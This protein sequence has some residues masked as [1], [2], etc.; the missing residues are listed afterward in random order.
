VQKNSFSAPSF[1]RY[2]VLSSASALL[3]CAGFILSP[4]GMAALLVSPTPLALL[5]ARENKTW[6]TLGLLSA[7]MA[8]WFILG[9]WFTLYFLFGY[10]LLCFGL[11]MPMGK[12]EKGSECLLFCVVVSIISKVLFVVVSVAL[13]GSNPFDVDINVLNNTYAGMLAT[14]DREADEALSQAVALIPYMFPFFIIVYSMCDSFINYRLC[15]ILQSK[16]EVKFPPLPPF[17]EW[18]FPSSILYVLVF[19]FAL[20]FV[21]ESG[22]QLWVMLELNLR[23]IVYVFFFLQGLALVWWW[24]SKYAKNAAG[25]PFPLPLRIV[26]IGFLVMPFFNTLVAALGLGDICIDFR[27]KK[28]KRA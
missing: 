2:L 28:I 14:G 19:A 3:F 1:I 9:S 16:H 22:D 4:L 12:L 5:G 8:V 7:T 13:S 24:L 27:T 26:L 15:E 21:V 18:R 25:R 23:L 11:T 20:P 10:G 6:M 17:G